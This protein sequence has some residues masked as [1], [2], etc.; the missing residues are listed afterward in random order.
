MVLND[1]L[2]IF[3]TCAFIIISWKIL[4]HLYIRYKIKQLNKE[5]DQL[6]KEYNHCW[7]SIIGK[8]QTP[9]RDKLRSKM[10]GLTKRKKEIREEL[11]KYGK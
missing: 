9:E 7:C 8:D 2:S 6:E 10:F 1:F 11:R 4:E 5:Y 3:L